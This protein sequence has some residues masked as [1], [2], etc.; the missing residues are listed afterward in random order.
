M[1]AVLPILVWAAPFMLLGGGEDVPDGDLQ[2]DDR[3]HLC[4]AGRLG[5]HGIGRPRPGGRV[6]DRRDP[7]LQ[8]DIRTVGI[9]RTQASAIEH[10]G[11][12]TVDGTITVR[13]GATGARE[14]RRNAAEVVDRRKVDG[15]PVEDGI[16]DSRRRGGG[17]E[18]A[19]HTLSQNR[20]GGEHGQDE[21]QRSQHGF[22]ERSSH[23][24]ILSRY[25]FL[26]IVSASAPTT[27]FHRSGN[28]EDNARKYH[29]PDFPL[30]RTI[31]TIHIFK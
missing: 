31:P 25:P 22:E 6:P 26:K 18:R 20:S 27:R 19:G 11:Q 1:L 12:V 17:A 10:Q 28:L 3:R 7:A 4:R 23:L 16:H 2:L 21:C 13:T 14:H 5:Q 29:P 8:P 24:G 30:N 9:I 15:H